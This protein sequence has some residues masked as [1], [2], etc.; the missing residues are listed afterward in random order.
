MDSP[1]GELTYTLF[2]LCLRM[3]HSYTM[4]FS[5]LYSL[6]VCLLAFTNSSSREKFKNKPQTKTQKIPLVI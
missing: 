4:H 6:F 2:K 3:Q 1:T 5:I